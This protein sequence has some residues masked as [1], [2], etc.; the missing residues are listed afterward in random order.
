M[1][2]PGVTGRGKGTRPRRVEPQVL[3]T[4]SDQLNS[5]RW[6]VM[7]RA[8]VVGS[9]AVMSWWDLDMNHQGSVGLGLRQGAQEDGQA[10]EMDTRQKDKEKEKEKDVPPGDRTP[11]ALAGSETKPYALAGLSYGRITYLGSDLLRSDYGNLLDRTWTVG[12]KRTKSQKGGKDA[13]GASGPVIGDGTNPTQVLPTQTGLANQETG[14]PLAPTLPTEVQVDNLGE[15]H[16][17]GREEEGESSH[18]GDQVG[19][20]T[21][22]EEFTEPSMRE[23]MDVVKAMGVQM[24]AFTRA[25]TPLVNSSVGQITPVQATA[26]ATQRAA[27]TA[28][29]AAGVARAAAQVARTAARTDKEKQKD[30]DVPPGE[31]TPKGT[32]NLGLGRFRD[33]VLGLGRTVLWSDLTSRE[34]YREDSGHGK[35]CGDWVIVD[36]CEGTKRTKARKG[37]E[38]AGASGPVGGDGTNPTQVFPTQTGLVNN[39]TGLGEQQELGREEEGESSHAGDLPSRGTGALQLAEPSMR[40]VLDVV[41]AIMSCD[42]IGLMETGNAEPRPWPDRTWTVVKERCRE[43]SSQGKMCGEWV[44]VDRCEGTKRTKSRKGKEAAGASVPVVGDGTNPTQVLPTQTGLVNNE[45]GEPLEPILPTEVQVD[46]LG[47]QQELGR[48]EEDESSHAGDQTGRGTGAVELAEPSMREVLDVVKAMGTQMLA[49]TLAFTSLVNSSVGQVTPAQATAQATQRAAQTSGTTAGV[50]QAAARVARTAARTVEDRATVKADVM[51]IDP[52]A[53]PAR[54]VDYLSLFMFSTPKGTKRTKSRMGKEAAGASVPVVGDGTNPTQVLPTQTGLVNN[55]T[56][57]PLEPILPTEVQVDNLGEQHELGREEEGDSSPAGDQT[58]RGT[59][60][61]ELAKP[62]MHEVL[63]VV[64]A[65][66]TQMLAVTRAFTPLVNF[67]VGQITPAQATAQATQIAAQTAG[68][69]VGVAQAAA[70]VARTAARTL[71]G[72]DRLAHSAGNSWWPAQLSSVECYGPGRCGR[73]IG[74]YGLAKGEEEQLGSYFRKGAKGAVLCHFSLTACAGFSRAFGDQPVEMDT[75]QKDKEKEKEKDVPPGERTPK[76]TL[77]P[78]LGRAVLWSDLI[79]RDRT[80]TMVKERCCEDSIQGKMCGEWVI[81]DRCELG[82]VGGQLNLARWSVMVR[83]GVVGSWAVM[84][85]WDLDMNHQGSVGL[86]LRQGTQDDVLALVFGQPKGEEEQLGSYFRKGAKWAVLCPFS[87]TACAGF[88]RQLGLGFSINKE[89]LSQKMD[90]TWTVVKERCRED[91][92][93]GKMCGEWIIVDRCELG[94]VGGQLNS[95]R[96]SVMVRA[97][98][99]GSWAIMGWWDLDMNHQGSVGLGLRQGTQDDVLGLVFGQPKGEEEQLDSYFRKGAKGAVLCPFSLTACAGFSSAVGARQGEKDK[100][101]PPGERTPKMETGNAE[102]RPWPDRTWT[103]VK[104][105]C[106]EDSSQGKMC[107]EWVIVDR[108]EVLIAYCANRELMID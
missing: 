43:D 29:T 65:M 13:A 38:V 96:W 34:R 69:A 103:V 32:L 17:L 39:E 9:W 28:G 87:L 72:D 66:G 71:T 90:R 102:P 62:S 81:V 36:K 61:V 78:G 21:G 91:S 40:E 33:K 44:I 55:E 64:K 15:Q 16:E 57:E 2:V 74:G 12:T 108:C 8:G 35:M 41:K 56:G 86:G 51:E 19:A 100:D 70:R 60:A 27:Q 26:Q 83:A 77:N 89:S 6:S 76:G 107:G 97:G 31:R 20:G 30:R 104:E 92:S 50:A 93:Q 47:E 18:A 99:V 7:V 46:N 14:E 3:G 59:G 5:A 73:V 75:R 88:S 79:S 63:D 25:F 105:R 101:V 85:W 22:A 67:S 94:T 58:G 84:G 68:T 49:F 23:V 11:K 10:V 1:V 4:V 53:R 82:T 95:A 45:T 37:K 98:V 42:V 80:W 52:P 54:R 48:E 106:H 24:L